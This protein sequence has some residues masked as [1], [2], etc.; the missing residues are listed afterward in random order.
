MAYSA[1][2]EVTAFV[3]RILRQRR[4]LTRE[5]QAKTDCIE[6]LTKQ[7]ADLTKRVSDLKEPTQNASPRGDNPCSDHT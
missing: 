3:V 7:V 2:N 6:K 4:A 1:G 5:V